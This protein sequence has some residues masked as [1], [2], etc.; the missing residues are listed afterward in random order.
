MPSRHSADIRQVA[1]KTGRTIDE[2]CELLESNGVGERRDAVNLL[3]DGY[4]VSHAFALTIADHCLRR[5][6][7]EGYGAYEDEDGW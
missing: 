6:D 5:N 1:S 7:D 4:A 3:R 2:W